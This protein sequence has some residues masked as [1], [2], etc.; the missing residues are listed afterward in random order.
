MTQ[1]PTSGTPPRPGATSAV[2][3]RRVIDGRPGPSASEMDVVVTEEPMEVRIVHWVYEDDGGQAIEV[4][5]EVTDSISVTMRTPGHD[6]ELAAG[7]L[8][9]EGV[10]PSGEAI[11]TIAYC[12]DPDVEQHYNIVNV[13]LRDGV[14]LDMDRLTRH[15]YTTSSCGICGKAS[16]DAIHVRGCPILPMGGARLAAGLVGRLP[17]KLRESQRLFDRTGGLHAAGLFDTDGVPLL[18]R[19]DVGRHNAVDKLIGD[20][21]LA[22]Q[23]PAADKV[24]VLSGRSSFELMQK[25][26]VAGI[27]IVVA[28][29]APSSLAVDLAR[30]FNIT[31]IGFARGDSYNIYAGAERIIGA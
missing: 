13:T 3:V 6:F 30:D 20:Q 12:T 23:L 22:G 8:Y 27:P 4:P 31:L 11:E 2:M 1:Q 9:G 18:V 25:A 5:R 28:V 29:G 19:E 24:L 7:F 17:A 16:L 26:L 15:F 10:I 21:A 14:P